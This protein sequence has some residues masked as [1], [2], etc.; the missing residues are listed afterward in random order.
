MASL[1]QP[2]K[3]RLDEIAELGEDIANEYFAASRIE[4]QALI[5]Q[6]GITLSLGDY[7]RAFD[8]LLEHKSGRFHIYCNNA[9]L[10]HESRV[11]FTLGHELGHFFLADHRQALEAGLPPHPSFSE[12][13]SDNPAEREADH[14]ASNLLMPRL[15]FLEAAQNRPPGLGAVLD[16]AGMFETSWTSTTLR[17]VKLVV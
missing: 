8:G 13:Q 2:T 4:P 10:R 17:Y 15:R 6:K 7:G 12:Y 5:T 1:S 9:R 11:R 14:F 16:L 3:Q